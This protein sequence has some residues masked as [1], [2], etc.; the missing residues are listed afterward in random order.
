[1]TECKSGKLEFQG[2]KSRRVTAEFSGD[3]M[4]SD[5]GLLLLRELERK[6]GILGRFV[7]SCF[8]DERHP[9]L[10]SYR[11]E[12]IVQQR[13]YALCAGYEDVN[14]HDRLR[15]DPM[16]ALCGGAET[17][18]A[19]STIN[20][21]E[22][23]GRDGGKTYIQAE[24]ARKFFVREYLR[25][26]RRAPQ[27][28]II[29]IDANAVPLHGEQ[30]QRCFLAQYDDYCYLPLLMFIDDHLV[31]TELRDGAHEAAFGVVAGLKTVV[32]HLRAKFP[33]TK[34]VVRA[35]SGF[36]RDEIMCWCEDNGVDYV[37]GLAKNS[38]LNEILKPSMDRAC[39]VHAV[40]GKPE[41][42]FADFRY[43]TNRSW[44]RERRVI[45]KAEYLEYGANPRYVVTSLS[46]H[47]A[48]SLYE[49]IYCARGNMENRIKEQ[50]QLFSDR[51]SSHT[52]RGNTIRHYLSAVAYVLMSAFR[53]RALRKTAL[54]RAYFDTIRLRLF[55]I[56]AQITY[57]CRRIVIRFAAGFALPKVF[58]AA[59]RAL[60]VT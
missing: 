8:I 36:C 25:T 35:D 16:F 39:E 57:S 41:R 47:G 7:K 49:E 5:G 55:K 27:E 31:Y 4:T 3:R 48:R 44:T 34:I 9:S 23:A 32:D 10:I 17:L 28:V 11:L 20:R 52:F 24:S 33:K 53:R 60:G 21:L 54:A 38:R 22:S 46:T 40:T 50:L 43:Q 30:E 37:L 12:T 45:G 19:R 29:D 56:G 58:S 42:Q 6:E 2:D 13:V 1:M 51:M 14:D 26:Q 59:A 15:H 18:A